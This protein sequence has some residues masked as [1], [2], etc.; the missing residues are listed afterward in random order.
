MH[1][2]FCSVRLSKQFAF[3]L[4]EFG[5]IRCETLK[6]TGKLLENFL[7]TSLILCSSFSFL[8]RLPKLQEKDR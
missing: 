6:E 2:V 7:R 1:V 5:F 4:V 3:Q 8:I